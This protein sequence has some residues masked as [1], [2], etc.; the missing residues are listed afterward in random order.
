MTTNERKI[1]VVTGATRG[2]GRA[3]ATELAKDFHVI[4]AARD[5]AKGEAVARELGDSAFVTFDQ[6]SDDDVAKLVSLVKDR[7]LDVLVNNAGASFSGFSAELADK[8]LETN[9][10]GMMRL[11]DRVL[12][13]LRPG[14]RIVMLSSG[15]GHVSC[16]SKELQ[17]E[18]LS[19]TLDRAG[20]L[21]FTKRFVDAIASDAHRAEGWPGNAYSVSK[22]AMNGYVRVLARELAADPR[23]IL[24][25][26]CD[27]GWVR[28]DMGGSSAPRSVAQGARTPVWLAKLGKDGPNGGFFRDEKPIEW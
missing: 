1:A 12:P 9:F 3:I 10:R 18:V 27:P 15:M 21:A 14:A 11:T 2:I 8:T 7:G 16:L 13:H 23:G 25:N 26:S 17:R 28:T 20:L 4:L 24:V 5:A 19:P 6:T 22:V